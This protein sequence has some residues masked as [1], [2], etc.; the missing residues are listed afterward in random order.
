[1]KKN[2]FLTLIYF[3]FSIT[4]IHADDKMLM[5]LI[6]SRE[7]KKAY[8]ILEKEIYLGDYS[9]AYLLAQMYEGGFGVI[10]NPKKAVKLYKKAVQFYKIS[11]SAYRLGQYYY[12][13]KNVDK[14]D[15]EKAAYWWR[16]G[17]TLGSVKAIESYSLMN[18]DKDLFYTLVASKWLQ[19]AK[20]K[21]SKK[22]KR[23]FK[24]NPYLTKTKIYEKL[25]LYNISKTP[26]EKKFLGIVLGEK[27][28]E[29]LLIT[30][31][32]DKPFVQINR[33][34]YNH[35]KSISRK[36]ADHKDKY[37]N[38]LKFLN[39][40]TT[41]HSNIVYRVR[42][43][44]FF[45]TNKECEKFEKEYFERL[46]RFASEKPSRVKKVK[47]IKYMDIGVPNNL[48]NTKFIF[49]AKSLKNY[50]GMRH[51]LQHYPSHNKKGFY[52]KVIV[53]DFEALKLKV[54]EALKYDSFF[55]YVGKKYQTADD[56]RK[57]FG[58]TFLEK[59]PPSVKKR[60]ISSSNGEHIYEIYPKHPHKFFKSYRVTTSVLTD[61]IVK[62]EAM[63][64]FQNNMDKYN[65]LEGIKKSIHDKFRLGNEDC[66]ND[67][68]LMI[69]AKKGLICYE[70]DTGKDQ[71]SIY[72]DS[73]KHTFVFRV[74]SNYARKLLNK[75]YWLLNY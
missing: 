53:L 59:I 50:K 8:P 74:E 23:I 39:V 13:G 63:A 65:A 26:Y 25:R 51:I 31:P 43:Y 10:K 14:I 3:L 15:Y 68:K 29:E 58:L 42:G 70:K 33:A 1:M 19:Y 54:A 35:Y 72:F 67:N 36:Y 20:K 2:I 46:T 28:N 27:F 64:I 18:L 5:N 34:S 7:Y 11:S 30:T 49:D 60:F 17:A 71:L 44:Y 16:I 69:D 56:S 12:Y 62:I 66:W 52:E 38:N 61:T 45:N 73:K 24:D 4:T 40:K 21:G 6:D 48:N 47:N 22:A 57:H 9:H 55:K 41:L 75:E 37:F 32:Q